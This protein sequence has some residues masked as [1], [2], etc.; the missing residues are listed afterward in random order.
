M[1]GDG[2][3]M[4]VLSGGELNAAVTREIVRIHTAAIGRGPRSP[5][6]STAA[7]RSSSSYWRC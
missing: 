3:R 5:T 1:S 7:R 6:P 4:E 2:E